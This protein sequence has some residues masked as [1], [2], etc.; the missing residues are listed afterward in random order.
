MTINNREEKF[1]KFSDLKLVLTPIQTEEEYFKACDL[2]EEIDDL[3]FESETENLKKYSFA[4]ALATLVEAYE[5]KNFSMFNTKLTVPQIIEQALE[6]QNLTK[7]DLNVMLGANRVSE[8]VNGKRELS[9][10]QIRILHKEL[11]IPTDLL[12]G[13]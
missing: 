13:V 4:D 7:K 2:L 8:I 12:I 6:Q 5:M 10:K 11:H 9:L 1:E 3:S